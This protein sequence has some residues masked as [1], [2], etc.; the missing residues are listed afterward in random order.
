MG[1][2]KTIGIMTGNSLDA[3]DIVLTEFDSGKI[4]DIAAHTKPYPKEL[5]SKLLNLREQI[6]KVQSDMEQLADDETFIS[7]VNEYTS[8]V[9][10]TV[11]EFMAQSNTPK[12]D[13]AAIGFHGQTCDHFPPSIAKD[14]PAYTLQVGN[15]Q[16]LADLT[17]IPVIYD[18]RSDDI[19]CG[20]EGAPLAPVHNLH[21]SKDLK[22]KGIFPVA[23]CNAGNTGNIAIISEDK[24]GKTVVKGWDVGPFNHFS[25]YLVRT[26]KNINY[27]KDAVFAK[28]G[29]IIPELL[30]D[31]FNTVAVNNDGQNFYLQTP[32]KSSDPSWYRVTEN[33]NCKK[34]SFEDTLRTVLYLSTYAFYHTLSFVPENLKMPTNF[35]I[36]GGGWHNPL[37]LEDF[38]NLLIGKGLVLE[39]HKEIFANIQNRFSKEPA[40]EWSDKFGYSG[41]YMEARIFADMAYCR[42]IGEPFTYPE[43]SGC[44]KPVVAGIYCLPN[45]GQ[46][47]ALEK[48]LQA[49][50]TTD[51]NK[52][53][54][55]PAL[56]NRAYKGWQTR[57]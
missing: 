51:L 49:C 12:S 57:D 31:L 36:F 11:N 47:Y 39:E 32:P 44:H 19:M 2:I 20:G 52:R 28:Q 54:K 1:G 16:L 9:A 55:A 42:I 13:I 24:N 40:V 7:T 17:D 37:A 35:L 38:K 45:T 41:Q 25:D 21:I 10:E 53:V 50:N 14:K 43:G 30:R 33:V 23:F 46:T 18:F 29:K 4:K 48:M 27:D 6:K 56:W 5:T 22:T 3:V 15:A 34:Y 8:L 26:Y